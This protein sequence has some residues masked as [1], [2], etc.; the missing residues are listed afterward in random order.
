MFNVKRSK[1]REVFHRIGHLRHV[2][3]L[4]DIIVTRLQDTV[5]IQIEAF[6]GLHLLLIR[7]FAE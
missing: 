4:T 6:E 1:V 7:H 2:V 3:H 5:T